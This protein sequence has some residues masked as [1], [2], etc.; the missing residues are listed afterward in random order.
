M[1]VATSV[2]AGGVEPLQAILDE[3]IVRKNFLRFPDAADEIENKMQKYL[4]LLRALYARQPNLSFKK[5]EVI[6]AFMAVAANREIKSDHQ[7]WSE[8]Q[9]DILSKWC[10][11]LSQGLLKSPGKWRELLKPPEEQAPPEEWSEQAA[12]DRCH[13][14]FDREA[15]S[16]YRLDKKSC[17]QFCEKLLAPEVL[18]VLDPKDPKHIPT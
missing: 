14:V 4:P 13:V 1:D 12:E 11:R 9:A 8:T 16:A 15:Q 5:R 2:D 3:F 10:R 6:A 7:E 17:R 18:P